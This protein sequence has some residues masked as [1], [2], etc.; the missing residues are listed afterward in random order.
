MKYKTVKNYP[1]Y[2]IYEDGTC[3][4]HETFKIMGV[5][6]TRE[7]VV[8]SLGGNKGKLYSYSRL[9][10]EHFI[11]R[12]DNIEKPIVLHRDKDITNYHVNNLYWERKGEDVRK[13]HTQ[14]AL[15]DAN[16]RKRNKYLNKEGIREKRAEGCKN[17]R[18]TDYGIFYHRCCHWKEYKIV[19]PLIG[20]EAF[21]QDV[22][23]KTTHCQICN[24]KFINTIGTKKTCGSS[25]C[26][27]HDHESGHIRFIC[28]FKCN[29]GC[30]N[31][32]D[33]KRTKLMLE[34]N[35]YFKINM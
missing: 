31:V 12:P 27:D 29:T 30:L 23:T 15:D 24:V 22:Y 10:A 19:E 4:N 16:L 6:T 34:L 13:Y 17:W 35:R 33:N 25:R 21:W 32:W 26:L 20:W 1:Q 18:K 2:T 28:C 14:E 5:T 3:L 8:V 11:P 9:V 7:K